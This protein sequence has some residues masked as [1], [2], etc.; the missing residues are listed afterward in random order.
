MKLT[1]AEWS[2]MEILWSGQRF[3]LKDIAITMGATLGWSKNTVFTY[4]TR[5]EAKGLVAIDR[6]CPKPYAAAVTRES[7]ARQE[8][9]ELLR[10]VYGGAA[11][12]LIAAFL[13]ESSMSAQEVQRLRGLLDEM[14]V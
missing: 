3:A 12:D 10:K 2:L 4:L 6:S 13:K 5:M 7:C 14:E 8:R 1:E 9:Q 11:G